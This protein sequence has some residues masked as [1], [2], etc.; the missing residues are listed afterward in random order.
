MEAV[1][2]ADLHGIEEVDLRE[3]VHNTGNTSRQIEFSINMA[4][5]EFGIG[6][7]R[8]GLVECSM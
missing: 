3:A 2:H 8:V 4:R 7:F 1:K 5:R 6:A